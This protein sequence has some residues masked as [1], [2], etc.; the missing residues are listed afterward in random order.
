MAHD[1][2]QPDALLFTVSLRQDL[3]TSMAAPTAQRAECLTMQVVAQVFPG[4]A[5]FSLF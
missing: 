5:L 1:Y 3:L 4:Y 2:G